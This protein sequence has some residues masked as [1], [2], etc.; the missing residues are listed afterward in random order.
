MTITESPNAPTRNKVKLEDIRSLLLESWHNTKSKGKAKGSDGQSFEDFEVQLDLNLAR[1][2]HD[3]QHGNYQPRPAQRV[4]QVK[5]NGGER[6]ITVFCVRDRVALGA[7]RKALARELNRTAS[8]ASF[9]Y[10]EG[11]GAL[12]AAHRLLEHRRAGRTWVI[13]SDIK[14]FFDT[15]PHPGLLERLAVYAETEVLA[16]LEDVLQTPIK[17]GQ[18]LHIP[19]R[20]IAQGSS[21][22]P[23]LSNFYLNAFDAAV[24]SDGRALVRYADDFV[25]AATSVSAAAKGLEVAVKELTELGLKINESKTQIVSFEQG[26]DFLGFYFNSDSVRVSQKS[27]LEFKTHLEGLLFTRL[28]QFDSSGVKR[29]NDL[30]RGWRNYYA[31]GDVR[32]DYVEL[33]QWMRDRFGHKSKLLEKLSPER[34]VPKAPS[35]GGYN[36]PRRQSNTNS[37]QESSSPQKPKMLYQNVTTDANGTPVTVRRENAILNAQTLP[38]LETNLILEQILKELNV[39]AMFHR[40]NTACRWKTPNAADAASFLTRAM[41]GRVEIS[42]ALTH[43]ETALLEH[44]NQDARGAR[45]QLR[46]RLER[47]AWAA[48]LEAGLDIGANGEKTTPKLAVAL[49][50]AFECLIADIALLSAMKNN[51]LENPAAHLE[52]A[53]NYQPAYRRPN[54]TKPYKNTAW[55]HVLRLEAVAIKL[56][57]ET[58]SVYRA[59]KFGLGD[60]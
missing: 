59:F 38:D 14:D 34:H 22:S 30:I 5:D 37:K 16:L 32:K 50:D 53:L 2:E 17:D 15:I 40:A 7:I 52:R 26:F 13:R 10:R 35:L 6:G 23:L 18:A 39:T 45:G 4:W 31:L 46:A 1:L 57:L 20:G 42:S 24:N 29:A 44:S 33:E 58:G 12:H 54:D 27:I 49:S 9:A 25:I 43:Y 48:L 19:E 28:E 3:L 41:T 47:T 55:L 11:L 51:A 36:R 60:A 21:I 8:N 56:T